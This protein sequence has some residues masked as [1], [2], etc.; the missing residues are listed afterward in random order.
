[1]AKLIST[2][3][4]LLCVELYS[5][6]KLFFEPAT[7][8]VR[9]S[10]SQTAVICPDKRSTCPNG[11]TC[12]ALGAGTYGC[13]PLPKAVCCNDHLHCCP[14]GTTCDVTAGKCN[15]GRLSFAMVTK[16]AAS[17]SN[18]MLSSNVICPDQ[19]TCPTG[20][21]CCQLSSGGYG[22]CPLPQAV[23]CNDHLHCCPSGTTCDVTA[24]KCNRADGS[25]VAMVKKVP[26]LP[27][28]VLCPDKQGTCP[29]GSTCCLLGSGKYGCCPLPNAVCCKDHLH[30][31]PSGTTC[32]VT[33]G[34]CNRGRLSF[35]MVTKIAASPSN[36]MLPSNVICP[37]QG[38][39]PTGNTCCLLS[40]GGYGCCPLPQAVCCND[41]L[42]C[43]P[44]GTTC[45]VTAGKCNRAD[46]SSVAMVKK[47][48][49]LPQSVL[50]PDKQ[51]TCPTGSTC[52]LL[53]SGKYGCCPLPNAVCCKDHL[54]CCPSGTTCDVTAGKCNRGRLSFAMVT[55]IAAS[56]SNEMLSSNVICPDQGTC[57]TGN[58]CCLLSSGGYGCCPLPQAVC[59]S[60]RL[61][62]CPSGTTCD[63]T[64]GKCNR[65]DGSSVAM[66]KKV[67]AL[68]Q[69]VLCPDKQGTCPTGSTCC[70]LG[71]GKYGCCPLPNA[72]CC[73]DHLH[74]CPSGTTCDVTAGKCNRADGSSVAMVK[75]VPALPQSV[76][77]PDKQGTCPTGST[78]CLLGSGKYGCCPLPNAVCCKD[79]LHCC[80]SGTTCDVTAG[81]CNRGRLSFAMVTKIAASPSNEMLPSNV[82]C[83]DQGTCPTGNTC[84][85]LSSGGYG[86]CPLPQA[87]CCSDRL[88]CCPSGT[89][90][91]V[92]A[93]K[94]NRADGSSVA[95]VK[96]VP[97]L[98]QSVLC[99]DKQGT[100][101]TGST[102]CL[103]TS[104]TYG[105]CPLPNAVCCKDHLHCCPAGTTCDTVQSKCNRGNGETVA[106]VKKVKAHI[107]VKE[108]VTCPD[109]GICPSGQKC[110]KITAL[111]YG[112]CAY[113]TGVCC[114]GRYCCPEGS[115]CSKTH[116]CV[117]SSRR[118]AAS[119]TLTKSI[120][121]SN[122]ICP[123]GRSQCPEASTCCK[124]ASKEYG[125]CPL[126]H[127]V[128]CSD[129]SHCCPGG[130]TC[131]LSAG[132][133]ESADGSFVA[134]VKKSAAKSSGAVES[135]K[136]GP[137]CPDKT[138]ACSSG[139]TCCQQAPG[140]YGCC[141]LPNAVCCNNSNYC[142]PA[143]THCS[144]HYTCA[145]DGVVIG[146]IAKT[147]P[148]V[149]VICDDGLTTC[150]TNWTC[151]K[152]A[153]GRWG[154]C[155]FQNA[156]CCQGGTHCCPQSDYCDGSSQTCK[157][158]LGFPVVK[159]ARKIPARPLNIVVCPG[160]QEFCLDGSTCCKQTSGA[161]G[162]CPLP[163][164]VCCS[165]NIHCCPTGT[166]CDVA[167][168]KC[169]RGNGS[170]LPMVK[171][172][173]AKTV[174]SKVCPD[175]ESRCPD[176]NTCCKLSTGMYGCCPLPE[177]DC[178]SDGTHCCP[179]TY[180][181]DTKHR[182]CVRNFESIPWFEKTAAISRTPPKKLN[183]VVCPGGQYQCPDRTTCCEMSTP[184]TYGC[185]PQPLAVCCSDHQHCCPHGYT[186]NGQGQCA[187]AGA[188]T[189]AASRKLPAKPRSE[190]HLT[191]V[192]CPDRSTCP[193]GATCCQLASGHFGCCPFPKAACCKD[194][195][196]CCPNGYSCS[197]QGTCVR[198]GEKS[199]PW[200]KKTAAK[201][202]SLKADV[203]E[204]ICPDQSACPNG[205]T[206]C[207]LPNRRYGCC[208]MRNA[209]CC[210]DHLHCCPS[211][212][213]CDT[214]RGKCNPG[215]L[216]FAVATKIASARSNEM[217]P[218]N[219]ICPGG[220]ASCPTGS[221]CCKL[222]SGQYG[223]CPIPNAVCCNDHLHC[224]PSGTT[225]D[226]T[227]GKCNR[228]RFSFAMVT[229][230][231]ASSSNEMLPS[232]VICPDQGTC[233]TGSTCCKLS[234]G[235]YGCCPLPNAVCC[236]DGLHC[237][238]AD[239]TCDVA[240]G[241]CNKA[242]GSSVDMVKKVASLGTLDRVKKTCGD[243][244]STCPSGTTC[245][246]TRGGGY[247]CCPLPNAVCC[248]DKIHCC[249]NGAKCDVSR[250]KCVRKT[251]GVSF[252]LYTKIPV[253]QIQDGRLDYVKCPDGQS[254][255][256]N[257]E[258]CCRVKSGSYGCCPFPKATCCS[259]QLHCCPNGFNCDL[260][261]GRCT[262]GSRV[263]P[264]LARTP[265][266]SLSGVLCPDK[267]AVC[268][269]GNTCC[270]IPGGGYGCCPLVE[271]N[272]K[273]DQQWM[274][275]RPTEMV[276]TLVNCGNGKVCPFKHTCCQQDNGDVGCCPAAKAV[277]C[278]GSGQCC[279][280]GCRCGSGN[281]CECPK[282]ELFFNKIRNL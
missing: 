22:C 63:V 184:G 158:S 262:K 41:H 3:L 101:P 230:I 29:T 20:N 260:S 170:L 138:H 274:L 115:T 104:G 160:G 249:P 35:A 90:C 109:G 259:D 57:P 12:C 114:E 87:V 54:H 26:A 185:C 98:P 76:L 47:L 152:V 30:C 117:T 155:P 234:T 162:C 84:C 217:R 77:C 60:D 43:C 171:K 181:C 19:G 136:S 221:T 107:V 247:A 14:S 143:G 277:C 186:C 281:T 140:K 111:T 105:C 196:H 256:H 110:C 56:S 89:T 180:K 75:K 83:P 129:G 216:S 273:S 239:T 157:N 124:L 251:D 126:P 92:T 6:Q 233:P 73:N 52:C 85:L 192:R 202:A 70:L 268:P 266:S 25:S 264:M 15:R 97:A 80:P 67:P 79:H 150:P 46:G 149:D 81:K 267:H 74:C 178:C 173:P 183:E 133:C 112:C 37:D 276:D 211:G 51:G 190:N 265:A 118:P 280:E 263:V 96:K 244:R 272:A 270:L 65:A 66:V 153:T 61:H 188:E 250:G 120:R 55:K 214:P 137:I 32:D 116:T 44:S 113:H 232:N 121:L 236:K 53:G 8:P 167:H 132:K 240:Q 168:G 222:S 154:C 215:K 27:Q 182:K 209:V 159:T 18:E 4:L 199:I 174:K 194:R 220:Q 253:T 59:C 163:Q 128:C 179:K 106:M 248:S 7:S 241:K 269:D 238:P 235:Q 257:G 142:C 123:D 218:S 125:C 207:M 31:C 166:K 245:C 193:D 201:P 102:C 78:C 177:A 91:D 1:M 212:T 275:R 228:G 169:L 189:I 5:A 2:T 17:P 205:N 261:Q 127:A 134:L 279:P 187:K 23:C 195:V 24:G 82:I 229:K 9:E 42:H 243:G 204:V 100:C 72:V 208:P 165:D 147:L 206:C 58:T 278:R 161:W 198:A 71:S 191:L 36:E 255:C 226:V 231:A 271:G 11:S 13:C 219:V 203:S 10:S 122:I 69:S 135:L 16:I 246:A 49:A 64:A 252:P 28:S 200:L 164:A 131:N 227:A 175:R 93:G 50:C 156:H 148:P 68:P 139:N 99:P 95:M 197:G 86:C 176:D 33:A 108:N 88:H 282:H 225:C 172:S 210:E 103:L 223:C 21:T 145:K 45:D 144:L 38:T 48:P 39:C 94:C 40:S 141:P 146:A 213:T 224:C 119:K 151:C 258:T 130:T 34:K 62:C 242:D 254:E 237:C